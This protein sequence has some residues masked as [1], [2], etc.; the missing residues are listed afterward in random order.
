MNKFLGC[1]IG[2]FFA[3]FDTGT[4]LAESRSV[5]K[6]KM[7]SFSSVIEKE[8]QEVRDTFAKFVEKSCKVATNR[9]GQQETPP[10]CTTAIFIALSAMIAVTAQVDWRARERSHARKLR[11]GPREKEC[12][13]SVL[14]PNVG[15]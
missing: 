6:P 11:C 10:E 1:V 13:S 9:R 12:V 14:D 15:R 8:R 5:E 4:A 3:I 2:V 7:P